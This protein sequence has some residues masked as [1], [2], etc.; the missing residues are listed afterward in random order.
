MLF[1]LVDEVLQV[2]EDR[3]EKQRPIERDQETDSLFFRDAMQMLSFMPNTETDCESLVDRLERL[4]AF[5]L[6]KVRFE[7]VKDEERCDSSQLQ[8]LNTIICFILLSSSFSAF[9]SHFS[10]LN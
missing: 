10:P 3:V 2:L 6:N 7:R 4:Y 9:L 8:N 5:E 1:G